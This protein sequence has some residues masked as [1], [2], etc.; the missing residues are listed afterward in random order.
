MGKSSKVKAITKTALPNLELTEQQIA[1]FGE[2]FQLFD[3][4][5][6]GSVTM[7]ELRVV[8]KSLGQDPTDEELQGMIDEVD[9][10]G[11]GDMGFEEFCRLMLK[12]MTEKEDHN[13]LREA[14]KILDSDGSGAISREELKHIMHGFQ[15]SG[16]T[17]DEDDIDA[18]LNEC[19]Q[20]GDGSISFDEFAKVM[21]VDM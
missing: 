11:N 13:T 10:D 5:G 4:D 2:A 3:K 17:V 6:N 12:Q 15:K 18:M 8:F 14:F 1:E 20:D 19:D 21:T 16:E 7:D 9:H